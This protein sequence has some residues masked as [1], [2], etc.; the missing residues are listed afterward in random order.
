MYSAAPEIIDVAGAIDLHVH[1]APCVYPRIGDDLAVAQ[2]AAASGLRGIM[3]K[4]HTEPTV[5]RAHAV[6]RALPL[7]LASGLTTYGSITL[8][9]PVGGVNPAAVEAALVT[10][11]RIVWMPTVDSAAHAAAFGRTGAWDTQGRERQARAD[12][13][14]TVLNDGRLTD[15]AEETLALCVEAGIPLATG[16]L[17]A[18]EISALARRATE[19]RFDRLIVTHPL[20]R[21]PG[22]SVNG[23]R[24]LAQLGCWFEFTYCSL[25]PMWRHTT[26]GETAAAITAVGAERCFLSS[27]G[28]QPHNPWPHEGLRL[29]AQMCLEHGV[30]AATVRR[31]ICDNPAKL[32]DIDRE[33]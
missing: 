8:N 9:H 23:L 28:G 30:P 6:N 17:S 24:D 22:L 16:H 5:G 29:L 12:L 13:P 10:G 15:H 2:A 26:I 31:L 1:S 3:L 19:L 11:A 27:D 21:V 18:E 25:S 33:G 20:F 14:L 32:L 7:D 4:S